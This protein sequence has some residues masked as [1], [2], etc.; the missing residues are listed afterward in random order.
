MKRTTVVLS[1]PQYEAMHTLAKKRDLPFSELMRR[2][3]DVYLRHQYNLAPGHPDA[4]DNT[5]S[6]KETDHA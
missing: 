2:A 1:D 6:T 3:I 5:D 4:Y